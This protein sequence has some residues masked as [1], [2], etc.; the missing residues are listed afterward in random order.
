MDGVYK[1]WEKVVNHLGTNNK[2]SVEDVT[3]E[4]FEVTNVAAKWF[5][6]RHS[7]NPI[8]WIDP[9][10]YVKLIISDELMMS[11]TPYE[12]RT[13]QKFV[14][15]AH[16]NVLIAGLGI[17]LLTKNLIPKIESGKI[18]H[19]S[20]WE[21]NTNLINLWKMAGQ[22]LPAHDKIS[23]FNYDVFDYPKVRDQLKGVFDSV[24]IDIWAELDERAYEQMKHFRH[25][26]KPLL[27]P[28]N[29][30]AF[31]ECWGRDICVKKVRNGLF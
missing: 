27:N 3:I 30:N 14:D 24:Y 23:I 10:K 17:G 18:K 21:K 15:N 8:N 22:Y 16:G 26:F 4:L 2:L 1:E 20:I 19:I 11:D 28:N 12:I 5:N 6:L 31:I 9:G 13:N 29:P 25:V 7:E